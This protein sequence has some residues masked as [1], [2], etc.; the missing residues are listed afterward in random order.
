[1]E[2]L[3]GKYLVQNRVTGAIME[4]PQMA[5]ALIAA[6]LF[7]RYPKETRLDY[8]RDYYEAISKHDISLPTPIMAGVRT[9]Q[10]QFSSCILMK[11]DDTLDSLGGTSAAIMKYVSQKTR[12]R[13]WCWKNSCCEFSCK[14]RRY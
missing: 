4:T 14:K 12:N 3:R 5:Y 1:M 8:V 13:N 11:T 2:Q 10:R 7:S 6:T 9:P